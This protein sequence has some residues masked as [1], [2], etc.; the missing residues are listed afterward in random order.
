MRKA[1]S[2]NGPELSRLNED[3]EIETTFSLLFWVKQAISS[4]SLVQTRGNSF[5]AYY[6]DITNRLENVLI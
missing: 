4:E 1:K 2:S 3:D 5:G 6:F